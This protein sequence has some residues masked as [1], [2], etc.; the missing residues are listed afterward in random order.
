MS[1]DTRDAATPV[2]NFWH[3]WRVQDVTSAIQ[4]LD[5]N[6]VYTLFVSETALPF[7]GETRGRDNLEAVF[8]RMLADWD[9]LE[10]EPEVV[11]TEGDLARVHVRFRYRHRR[12]GGDYAGTCRCLMTVA[13]GLIIKVDEYHDAP[14]LEAFMRLANQAE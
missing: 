12:S 10:V 4:Y 11:S 13:N 6:I 9:F 8:Y 5:E 2:E 7:G 3:Y 1:I 14:M